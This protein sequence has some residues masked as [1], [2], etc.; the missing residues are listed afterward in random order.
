[1]M[2]IDG[3]VHCFVS[4][5]KASTHFQMVIRT[6]KPNNRILYATDASVMQD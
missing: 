2:L 6:L 1:M 5:D 3:F 4:E